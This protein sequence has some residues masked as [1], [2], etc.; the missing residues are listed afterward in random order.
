MLTRNGF[1]IALFMVMFIIN[2]VCYAL[3]QPLGEVTQE[4]IINQYFKDKR[5]GFPEGIWITTDN[6]YEIA[7]VKNTSDYEREYDYIGVI[8]NT[9]DNKWAQG[10]IKLLLKKTSSEKLYSGKYYILET[11]GKLWGGSKKKE[12]RTTFSMPN[13]NLLG[14]YL[15]TGLYGL[16]VRHTMLRMYPAY[17][18]SDSVGLQTSGTGFFITPSLVATNYHVVADAKSIE[19]SFQNEAKL[20]ATVVAKDPAN[21]LAILQVNGLEGTAKPASFGQPRTVKEGIQVFTVGYP[22]ASELGAQA[23]ISEGIVNSVT[24]LEDD[25]RMLQISVPIQPGNSGGPLYNAQGQ[26]IGIVTSTLNNR[27]FLNQGV[28]PQNVNY[29][30]KINFLRNLTSML[31]GEV[32]IAENESEQSLDA[33]QIMDRARQSV[34][35]ILAKN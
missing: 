15:P 18:S 4:Q 32:A 29:A 7:I 8:T 20:P 35:F 31:P 25:I 2:S 12:Y 3:P 11:S 5:L 13:K 34:V 10:E 1:I 6:K 23:K 33:P 27:Y 28:L 19:I 22:M 24:G 30:I 26:V 21:D 17:D 9:S 16:P 14:A